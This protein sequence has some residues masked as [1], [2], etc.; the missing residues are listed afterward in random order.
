M[1]R[2]PELITHADFSIDMVETLKNSF[3]D[4]AIDGVV[5]I[6][7]TS[8]GLWLPNPETGGRQFLGLAKFNEAE[9]AH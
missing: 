9:P 6:E 2:K 8:E 4:Y 3:R 7:V 5:S 1:I